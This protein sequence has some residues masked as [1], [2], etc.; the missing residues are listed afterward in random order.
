MSAHGL[1]RS[2]HEGRMMT[3]HQNERPGNV[4]RSFVEAILIDGAF[5]MVIDSWIKG[6][7]HL[8]SRIEDGIVA[9]PE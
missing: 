5:R 3:I 8:S 6:Q 1:T 7:D 9:A 4:G 2:L